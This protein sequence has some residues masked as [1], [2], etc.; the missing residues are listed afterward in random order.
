MKYIIPALLICLGTLAH[1]GP[2]VSGGIGDNAMMVECTGDGDFAIHA[3]PIPQ[4]FRGDFEGHDTHAVKMDCIAFA[5]RVGG[6]LWE[7]V[8][9]RA[10]EGQLTAL[11]IEN[12]L[13]R[14]TAQIGRKDIIGNNHV[15]KT[16]LCR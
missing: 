2:F 9:A 10:G 8:E 4:Q 1:A 14:R 6:A 12:V 13:G 7:C 16:L 3:T 15:L 11:V 5:P